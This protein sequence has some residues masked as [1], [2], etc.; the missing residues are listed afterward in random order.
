VIVMPRRLV[1]LVA[2]LVTV[3]DVE[4]ALTFQSSLTL[5]E[6]RLPIAL[7]PL[8]EDASAGA[9]YAALIVATAI[10]WMCAF[11]SAHRPASRL[12]I[13]LV[14]LVQ[15]VVFVNAFWHLFI[16]RV[17][18]RAYAPG[19]V[20]AALVN[21]PFSIYLFR[22]VVRE[23]WVPRAPLLALVPAALLVHSPIV[24]IWLYFE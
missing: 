21:L 1:Y 7:R 22:R 18:L 17:V 16:A 10:P 13:W 24:L 2:G 11:W 20:T 15:A 19:L 23:R 5:I 3:H 12:A 9:M 6:S 8:L 14:L 4:E